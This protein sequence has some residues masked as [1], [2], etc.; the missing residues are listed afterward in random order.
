MM[1]HRHPPMARDWIDRPHRRLE[2][3][4][5]LLESGETI[6]DFVLSY[7]VHGEINTDRSNAVLALPALNSTHHRLDFL[8]GPGRALDPGDLCIICVD[9]IANG[10]TT[11]PSNSTRQPGL[12]FPRFAIRDMVETQRRL[13]QEHLGIERLQAVIGA[14]MGGMQALQWGVSHPKSMSRIV[15]MTPM[16]KTTP[17]S[18]AINETTRQALMADAAWADDTHECRGWAA[19]VPLMQLIAGRTPAA[20]AA[21]FADARA[22]QDWIAHRT[23]WQQEQRF[24]AVDLVYQTW[25]YDSHDVGTTPGFQGDT[26]RALAAVEAT[27]LVLAPPM[28]LFNPPEAAEAAAAAVPGAR[29]EFIPSDWGHQSASSVRGD[30]AA[31]LN[32]FIGSFLKGTAESAG[33]PS[34]MPDE[35]SSIG[36]L[37]NG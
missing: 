7:V 26:R 2:L 3:G 14:S 32:K 9:S 28:D 15:A 25:A 10:L 17:W 18:A 23:K 8:I 33:K 4:D 19:W 30:D 5:F 37:V 24:S 20:L 34:Q 1:D 29:F 21:E 31:W 36:R 35:N 11:S 22:V 6:H 12:Q 27:T 13:I 16:A